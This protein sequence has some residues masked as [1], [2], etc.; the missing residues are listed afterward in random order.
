MESAVCICCSCQSVKAS[1]IYT[2]N[3]LLPLLFPQP[4][5]LLVLPRDKVDRCVLQ[6]GG[7]HKQKTHRHPDVNGLHVGHLHTNTHTRMHK[8]MWA[9]SIGNR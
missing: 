7:K 6:Q 3:S 8:I 5:E 9:L 4:D 1:L 2:H